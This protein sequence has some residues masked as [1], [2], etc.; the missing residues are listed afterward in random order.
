[1]KSVLYLALLY[2][3]TNVIN[4]S[5]GG[6]IAMVVRNLMARVYVMICPQWQN[7]YYANCSDF[8]HTNNP[9]TEDDPYGAN[10]DNT[11]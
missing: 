11:T 1:M 8:T 6:R 3:A 9:D 5:N 2:I 4:T 7:W 10:P